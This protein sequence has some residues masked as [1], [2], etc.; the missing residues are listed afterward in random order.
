MASESASADRQRCAELRRKKE[1]QRENP[2]GGEG[3]GISSP[4]IG[5]P[6]KPGPSYHAS[7]AGIFGISIFWDF[8]LLG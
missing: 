2:G 8:R 5:R 6:K 7:T 3:G 1:G 4:I